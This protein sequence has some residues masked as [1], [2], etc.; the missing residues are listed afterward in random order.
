[1]ARKFSL[2][3]TTNFPKLFVSLQRNLR[4]QAAPQQLEQVLLRSVSCVPLVASDQRSSGTDFAV[5]I[6]KEEITQ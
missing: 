1:M 3:N 5:E 6:Y 2:Q 4:N